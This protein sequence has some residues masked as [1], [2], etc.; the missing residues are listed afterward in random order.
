[1]YDKWIKNKKKLVKTNYWKN[2]KSLVTSVAKLQKIVY[3]Q[4]K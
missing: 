2:W 3:I 4:R 1:M